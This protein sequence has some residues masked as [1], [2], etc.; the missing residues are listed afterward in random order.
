MAS[1]LAEPVPKAAT[2][3]T[4]RGVTYWTLHGELLIP[5][6][7]NDLDSFRQWSLEEP[8]LEKVKVCYL[9]DVIWVET[10]MED[11]F[12]H[13]RLKGRI[14][15]VLDALITD[16]DLGYLFTD[17]ARLT[18]ASANFACEP[19]ALFVSFATNQAG[20]IQWNKNRR[21][22]GVVE[23]E[24][25]PD[26][27]MEVISDSSVVKDTQTLFESYYRAGISEYWLVDARLGEL[28][29]EI[30]HRGDFSFVATVPADDGFVESRVLDRSFRLDRGVDPLGNPK[31][32]LQVR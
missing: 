9:G 13:N 5:S 27:V 2:Q 15:A 7:V 19:D 16:N 22:A 29:F 25:S 17:G 30:F 18:N 8:I 4:Y 31:F 26:M 3:S 10:E 14:Y 32:N 12:V 1:V 21:G 20:R 11:V 23:I 28:R 24:G 6:W